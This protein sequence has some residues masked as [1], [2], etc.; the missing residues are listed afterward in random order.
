M[1]RIIKILL[2]IAQENALRFPVL[3]QFLDWDKIQKHLLDEIS[4][5]PKEENNP[6]NL[7]EALLRVGKNNFSVYGTN[8]NLENIEASLKKIISILSES[9]IREIKFKLSNLGNTS[10]WDTATE[11]WFAS[12]LKKNNYNIKFDFPLRDSK[13]GFTPSNADVAIVDYNNQPI[14]LFDCIT[15]TL[16]L[17]ECKDLKLEGN[18][19][20][21]PEKAIE[22]LVA[23]IKNKF[24]K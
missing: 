3:N 6:F 21:E 8:S 22:C 19:I 18:F 5:K 14:W 9:D 20:E 10:F 2:G 16:E 23:I 13:K 24:E 15:P 1:N 12:E 4:Q 17:D 7:L 11:L